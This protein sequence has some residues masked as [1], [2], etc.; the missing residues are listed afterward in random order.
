[1]EQEK[2]IAEYLEAIGLEQQ[3]TLEEF[4]KTVEGSI[5]D[6]TTIMYF[7]YQTIRQLHPEIDADEILQQASVAFGQWKGKKWGQ[8]ENAGQALKKQS[9]KS[10]CLVFQQEFVALNDA[11]AEKRF[12]HCPHVAALKELGCSQEEIIN[13]CQN[14]LSYGDY[15]HFAPHTAVKMHFSKQLAVGDDY[16]AMCIEKVEK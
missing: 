8:V 9:S 6:R 7:I 3:P 12:Y 5:R 10:G 16:C 13:F 2:A 14:I 15:G 1:M 4:R 11:Y